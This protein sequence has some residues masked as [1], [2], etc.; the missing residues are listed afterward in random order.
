[1]WKWTWNLNFTRTFRYILKFLHSTLFIYIVNR[2]LVISIALPDYS[3]YTLKRVTL[4]VQVSNADNITISFVLHFQSISCHSWLSACIFQEQQ[5][6]FIQK[7]HTYFL[8]CRIWG[9]IFTFWISSLFLG[10]G[11]LRIR[12]TGHLRIHKGKSKIKLTEYSN[13]SYFTYIGIG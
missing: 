7:Q 11:T 9:T 8:Y 1:M 4:D 2:N 10:R 6:C 3:L 12:A 5:Y 13:G